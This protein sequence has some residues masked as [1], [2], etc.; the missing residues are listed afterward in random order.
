MR[1]MRLDGTMGASYA[2]WGRRGSGTSSIRLLEAKQV[3]MM[4]TMI[5]LVSRYHAGG[6]SLAR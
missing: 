1:S 3:T 5:I 6:A 4:S 2:A